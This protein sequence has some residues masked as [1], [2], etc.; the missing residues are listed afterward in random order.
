MDRLDALNL[1]PPIALRG[2]GRI[3][4]DRLEWPVGDFVG[5]A[6]EVM[7]TNRLEK[8]ISARYASNG[9]II[10]YS[11]IGACRE[12]AGNL[13][14]VSEQGICFT[15]D[16]KLVPGTTVLFKASPDSYRSTHDEDSCQLRTISLVTVKW[17][18]ES[19]HPENTVHTIGATYTTAY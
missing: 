7:M 2:I 12:I 10:L 6:E 14:N 19:S 8:R 17:C 13:V 11:T 18:H 1:E 9:S 15:T 4:V 3:R 16:R 5:N